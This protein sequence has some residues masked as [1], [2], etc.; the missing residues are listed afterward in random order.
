MGGRNRCRCCFFF[1]GASCPFSAVSSVCFDFSPFLLPFFLALEPFIFVGSNFTLTNMPKVREDMRITYVTRK[2]L[3]GGGG[4]GEEG[5]D[6]GASWLPPKY[7]S[8]GMMSA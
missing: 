6:G 8:A 7:A 2:G 3:R 4:G 5:E 1:F